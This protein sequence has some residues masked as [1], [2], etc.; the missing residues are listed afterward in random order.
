ML[1]RAGDFPRGFEK[2][3]HRFA[4]EPSA[5]N[6]MDDF[7]GA[8]FTGTEP[9]A[10][11][12]MLVL[13]EQGQGDAIQ[14]G[15]YLPMLIERGARVSFLV[16]RPLVSLFRSSMPGLAAVTHE[17]P[18]GS[19]FDFKTRLLS[20]PRVLGTTL[21]TIP[22]RVPYL[23]ADP[24]LVAAWRA[25]RPAKAR[26][27]AGLAWAG[28]A[29]HT[30]DAQRSIPLQMLGPLLDLDGVSFVSLQKEPRPGNAEF[31][32]AHPQIENV[33][34]DLHDYRDT[35]A[36]IASLDLVV[37]IDTSIAHLAGALAAPVWIMLP[38]A[39]DWRWLDGRND[40]PWYPTARLFRQPRMA[41]WPSVVTAV[42]AAMARLIADGA[43][44]G[45]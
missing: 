38:F 21:A 3:R 11:R 44:S 24:A 25:R 13:T 14:F 45:H 7:A 32:R 23:A 27:R 8:I 39:S 37:T 31:L 28:S 15:R 35:A 16:Q 26:L 10:G 4:A 41:D 29:A 42:R 17:L 33:A 1:L 36:A 22:D 6:L 30:N 12:S 40:S 34:A 5:Q 2:Y 9:L 43:A 19:R 18:R 20:L